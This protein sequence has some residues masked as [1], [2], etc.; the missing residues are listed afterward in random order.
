M[1]RSASIFAG[2][3]PMLVSRV[4]TMF[5]RV[6]CIVTFFRLWT[7]EERHRKTRVEIEIC[8]ATDLAPP[9]PQNVIQANKKQ[10]IIFAATARRCEIT[11]PLRPATP[12][13]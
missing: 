10:I 13:R 9:Q 5:K 1:E 12:P 2:K 8:R 11:C 3:R 7:H 4:A 6:R